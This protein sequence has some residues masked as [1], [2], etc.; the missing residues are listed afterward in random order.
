LIV[1]NVGPDLGRHLS[2]MGDTEIGA[3]LSEWTGER[4]RFYCRPPRS[5]N[6]QKANQRPGL[7][8]QG[9]GEILLVHALIS[10]Y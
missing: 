10:P 3:A 1:S 7:V 2:G 9:A 4:P 8:Y 6:E 5:C